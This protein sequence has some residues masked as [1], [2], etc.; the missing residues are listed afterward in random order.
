M[1]IAYWPIAE[2]EI[3]VGCFVKAFQALGYEICLSDGLEKGIEKIAIFGHKAQD[4]S[5]VPT[6]AS[7]Q[8]EN[9]EWTSKLGRFEDVIHPE[10]NAVN[11]PAYGRP[12]V[13]MSR[14]RSAQISSFPR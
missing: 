10:V 3:T 2:R 5:A 14:Q 13:F 1:G 4:G 6:H 9:G 7:L 8:L 11:G 12:L